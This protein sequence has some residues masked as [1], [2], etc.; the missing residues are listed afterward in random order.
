MLIIVDGLDGAGKSSAIKLLEAALNKIGLSTAVVSGIGSGEIGSHLR[1]KIV[2]EQYATEGMKILGFSLAILD[3]LKTAEELLHT[4]NIVIMD[5]GVASY[6]AYFN[7]AYSLNYLDTA[8]RLL[9]AEFNNML[10]RHNTSMVEVYIRSAVEVCMTRLA[11]RGKKEYFDS[12]SKETF[13]E[14]EILFEDWYRVEDAGYMIYTVD[15]SG[16]FEDLTN[17]INYLAYK[18]LYDKN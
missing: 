1:Q 12:A 16:S 18:I 13:M 17:Q 10:S 11:A 7:R 2:V 9:S 8:M 15:N 14:V 5:R 3:A 6:Y 4:T